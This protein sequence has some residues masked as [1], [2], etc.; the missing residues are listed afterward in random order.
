MWVVRRERGSGRVV[1][2]ERERERGKS[3]KL[4]L[5]LHSNLVFLKLVVVVNA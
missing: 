1:K 3:L 2:R 4:I 5:K